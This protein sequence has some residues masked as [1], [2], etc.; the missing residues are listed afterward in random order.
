[1]LA[2]FVVRAG[3]FSRLREQTP[4]PTRLA[5][6]KRRRRPMAGNFRSHT[7]SSRSSAPPTTLSSS[8]V[9]VAAA[10]SCL[11][12]PPTLSNYMKGT[13]FFFTPRRD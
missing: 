12:W 10:G 4:A 3:H 9:M 2:A 7:S 11:D 1:M 13:R 5:V 6:A 8:S